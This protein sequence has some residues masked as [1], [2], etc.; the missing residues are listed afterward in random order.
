VKTKESLDK[1][2]LDEIEALKEDNRVQE[3]KQLTL[4]NVL[5]HENKAL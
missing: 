3:H 4:Q 5:T 2:L 1:K